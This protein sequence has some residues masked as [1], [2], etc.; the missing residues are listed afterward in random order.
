MGGGDGGIPLGSRSRDSGGAGSGSDAVGARGDS[1]GGGGCSATGGGC[2]T[3]PW[4]GRPQVLQNFFPRL[5]V[6]PQSGY[7]HLP[8]AEEDSWFMPL[9]SSLDN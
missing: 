5:T 3:T 9:V 6:A 1:S 4:M 2:A 7:G 8:V